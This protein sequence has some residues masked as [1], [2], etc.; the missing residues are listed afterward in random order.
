M[1]VFTCAIVVATFMMLVAAEPTNKTESAFTAKFTS[2]LDSVTYTNLR[3]VFDSVLT[4]IGDDYNPGDGK[5]T[6]SI[7]GTYVFSV[8]LMSKLSSDSAAFGCLHKNDI[9]QFCVWSNGYNAH[10]MS[11]N[12]IT[13]KLVKGDVVDVVLKAGSS[14]GIHN[15]GTAGYC[16]FTGFL[17][18][19]QESLLEKL[20]EA[21]NRLN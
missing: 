8:T 7:P 10:E 9:E 18:Y 1:A 17:L 15:S 2:N 3:I 11:S 5:F 20:Q 13:L 16:S 6:A 19:P 4:N 21:I 12:T 14:Y